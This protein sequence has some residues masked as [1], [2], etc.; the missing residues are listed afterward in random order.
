MLDTKNCLQNHIKNA[1]V[2]FRNLPNE[3]IVAMVSGIPAQAE[4]MKCW[5]AEHGQSVSQK[6]VC[7]L[8]TKY[9][10]GAYLTIFEEDCDRNISLKD[11]NSFDSGST[12]QRHFKL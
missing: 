3:S 6:T 5:R 11:F 8:S 10:P 1:V 12:K 4:R 7:N 2:E 9:N